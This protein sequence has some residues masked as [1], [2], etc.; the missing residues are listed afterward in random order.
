M[1]GE[2][3]SVLEVWTVTYQT[4]SG[5]KS[6]S[7]NWYDFDGLKE[8]VAEHEVLSVVFEATGLPESGRPLM[9]KNVYEATVPKEEVANLSQAWI[10]ETR[11]KY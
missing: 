9:N 5:G 7:F 11:K 1:L 10:D 8:F 6:Q 4:P 3:M 2:S